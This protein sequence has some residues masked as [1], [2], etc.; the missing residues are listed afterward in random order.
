LIFPETFATILI[1]KINNGK[2][3][4]AF[5]SS[6]SSIDGE[7][8]STMSINAMAICSNCELA[9]ATV[10]CND[11]LSRF[12]GDGAGNENENES[13]FCSDCCDIHK[14]LKNNKEHTFRDLVIAVVYCCNC[15][16]N[17]AEYYC[18]DCPVEEQKYCLV[19]C[20]L[21]TKVKSTR[22]HRIS[23]HQHKVKPRRRSSVRESSFTMENL[24]RSPPSSSLNNILKQI[25]MLHE[26]CSPLN[27]L[28]ELVETLSYFDFPVSNDDLPNI[29]Y[30][31][32]FLLLLILICTFHSQIGEIIRS[33][34]SAIASI[35]GGVAFLRFVQN[36]KVRNIRHDTKVNLSRQKKEKSHHSTRHAGKHM[37]P[38]KACSGSSNS[39]IQAK[40][41]VNQVIQHIR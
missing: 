25:E 39:H 14:S 20:E 31:V 15:E 32:L 13:L 11:C 24:P 18:L 2:I 19:C 35:I 23:S 6:L 12:N 21:H 26:Y 4:S 1:D 37:V 38:F 8:K 3:E 40:D 27:F 41:K 33:N 9:T 28:Q 30:G 34:G 5:L 17:V 29:S 22:S 16:S 10:Q 36:S 7:L